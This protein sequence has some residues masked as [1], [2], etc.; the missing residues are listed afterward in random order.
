MCD[1]LERAG[2][3][4]LGQGHDRLGLMAGVRDVDR[5]DKRPEHGRCV[6]GEHGASAW[7]GAAII[8]PLF[9]E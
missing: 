1:P 9:G 8:G 2:Q 6:R 5:A 3:G 4:A 7:F